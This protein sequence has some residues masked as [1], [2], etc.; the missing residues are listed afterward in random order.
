MCQYWSFGSWF[1]TV[2]SMIRWRCL[3]KTGYETRRSSA[4]ARGKNALVCCTWE[5]LINWVSIVLLLSTS[6]S[7]WGSYLLVVTIQSAINLKWA[8]MFLAMN[9][10]FSRHELQYLQTWNS[11][12]NLS[13]GSGVIRHGL[14]YPGLIPGGRGRLSHWGIST[15]LV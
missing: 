8:N 15:T 2:E 12:S 9:W 3:T 13:F 14:H 1:Y 4:V 7:G 11:E 6:F 10:V 5:Q